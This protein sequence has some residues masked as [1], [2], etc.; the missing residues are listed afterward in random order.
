MRAVATE[1]VALLERLAAVAS[2]P[3]VLAL[4]M[5]PPAADG[6]R[7]GEFCAIELEDGS[8]GLSFVLLGDTLAALR[9]APEHAALAGI[10]HW[11]SRGAMPM[12]PERSACW[13]LPP[14][15]RSRA[16]CST[17]RATNLARRATRRATW[18]S[19]HVTTSA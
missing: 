13:A 19:R 9:G 3:R 4:H 17:A 7:D 10:R 15:T 1:M 2:L 5:P 14:S 12:A 18:S 6:T 11:I 16:T 8:L